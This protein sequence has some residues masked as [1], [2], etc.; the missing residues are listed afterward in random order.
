MF[1]NL[2]TAWRINLQFALL[3]FAAVTKSGTGTSDL[4]LEDSG[5]RGRGDVGTRGRGDVGTRGGGDA[6]T[7]GR[8]D[9]ETQGRGDAGTRRGGMRVRRNSETRGYSR[10]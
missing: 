5:T 10:T 2:K 6:G 4:G 1:L 8:G 3:V 9:A 7:R